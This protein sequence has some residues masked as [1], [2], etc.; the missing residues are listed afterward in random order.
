MADHAQTEEDLRIGVEKLLE[1]ALQQLGIE[2]HPHYERRVLRTTL[3]APG[4]ADA[5]Y[6]QAVIEYEPPGKL[7][8]ARG[9]AST[10]RQLEGYLLG[11]AGSGSQREVALRRMAG[12]GLDGR[13]IFFLRYR[14]D[15]PPVEE[16]VPKA[17]STQL[18]LLVEEATKGSFSLIGPYAVTE[19]SISHFLLHLR[20]LR[21]RPLAA[22]DLA[23]EFG[24]GPVDNVAHKMVNALYNRLEECLTA[25]GDAF[26]QVKTLYEEWKRIFG[27][28]Y[29][30]E[31]VKARRDAN[32]LARLY[33]VME[34]TD[35]KP[36]L[37]AVH[38]YYALLMKLLAAELLSL[39]QGALMASVVEQLPALP[40]EQLRGHLG[41]LEKGSWFESQG[42]RNLLEA[43]F[44]GWYVG[45]WSAD[46][47]E[48]VRSF[49]RALAEYE[50]A[51]ATLN[52]EATRDLLKKLYQYLVPR[53]LR[54]DLGEYYTPDWLAELVLNDVGYTGQ[55]TER[56]LDPACGSGTFLVL[57]I[58]RALDVK[59]SLAW[60]TRERELVAQILE[61]VVGFDLN[62]LAVIAARTN[63]LLA[64]GSLARHLAG[65]DIPVYLCDSILTPQTQR[66][67]KR[68]I[69]HQ[70]DIPVPSAQKEFWVP[71][72]LVDKGQVDALCRL[73]EQCVAGN[74]QTGEFLVLGQR[75]MKWEDLLTER[76]LAELY[77]K[78]R[79]LKEEGR[80][81]LWARI[82]KN[83]FAPVFR[84][85]TRFDYVVGNPPW[86]NW[87]S[88]ADDYRAATREL[89]QRY[90]LF[91]L[92][93]H[94]ARLGGGKKD[95]AMLMLY[96]AMDSYLKDGGKLGFVI[97]Q[98]VFKTKGAGDGF[99]RF[100][101]GEEGPHL[102]V[103]SAQDLVELQPFEG[104]SNRTATVV[105]QKGESTQYPVPYILWQKAKPGRIGV[106]FTLQGVS[107]RTRRTLLSARPVGSAQPTSPWLTASPAALRALRNVIGP[108][109]YQARAGATTCGADGV[110]LC[111]I[112]EA[113]PGN[114]LRIQ[115]AA[116]EGRR[117]VR[118]VIREVEPDLVYPVVRGKDIGRW[119]CASD[120]YAILPQD[121][122]SRKAYDEKWLSVELPLTYEYLTLF[123]DALEARQS[124]VL[125]RPPFYAL[126]GF[127]RYHLKPFKVV[128]GRVANSVQACVT[129]PH[130][131]PWL[132]AKATVPFEAMVCATDT[133]DEAH[134][135]CACLNCSLSDLVVRAYIAVHPDTHVL[136]NTAI[137]KF[138]PSNA[139]HQSLAAHSQRAHQLAGQGKT[140]QAELRQVETEI[141]RLA[142]QLWGLS[143]AELTEIQRSLAEI[144]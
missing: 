144:S 12:I 87:E 53:E 127:G 102:K 6:G 62:P 36:L 44:F 38:T 37:F 59:D 1:P 142:A 50:P 95:V 71:E 136:K 125:P 57:A 139:L 26:P 100:R 140:A 64:L 21:R 56:L 55:P 27:I 8:T 98:T 11:L 9:L 29:G 88:L 25:P 47:E 10:R 82:I 120:T 76:S 86:V 78:V 58:H 133:D 81:G 30:Q 67:Q 35:L 42:I 45:A 128:W 3:T 65:K 108:S 83:A 43:D 131:V 18:P 91:S 48:A 141:D 106:D 54:H 24:P 60:R 75:E 130:D 124:K 109:A 111:H 119:H 85:A 132:G 33:H 121:A 4:R 16:A 135:V 14:G 23:K 7:T 92:K 123:K 32:A 31:L 66:A 22:E 134:Y 34:S 49:A 105:L 101:L 20:A 74:Y 99:R 89:W 84:S 46:I 112:L 104:A 28:V 103:L 96:A 80:N 72:E 126:Y 5:L 107:E 19:E 52:P 39:Q 15:K 129:R 40:G 93:G 110:F 90:G 73:L 61:N 117:Q 137:P 113:S 69:E 70:K 97:T 77:D 138:D 13:S 122:D 68:P 94:A 41:E 116:E 63:Y 17:Q 2:A 114:L 115:N 51:T 79:R 118:R 143:K